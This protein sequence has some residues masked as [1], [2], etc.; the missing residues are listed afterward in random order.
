PSDAN[1]VEQLIQYADFAMYQVKNSTKGEFNEFD[2]ISYKR[3]SFLIKKTEMLNKFLDSALTDY[4]FQPIVSAIDGEVYGYE[5]LMRS[6]IVDMSSPQEILLLARA[7]AKL[8]QIERLTWFE[9]ARTCEYH[10]GKINGRKIFINSIPNQML[11]AVD[12]S[13]FE[14]L[15][16][17][18][19]GQIVTELTENEKFDTE[20]LKVKQACARNWGSEIAIDDFGTGYNSE[21]L[22]LAI[23]PQYIKI[24]MGVVRDIH[25]DKNRQH[26]LQGL[27][28]YAHDHGIKVIAE[29]VEKSEEM[30]ILIE[31]GVDYMQGFYL[32]LVCPTPIEVAPEI[33]EEIKRFNT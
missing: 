10:K 22:L 11:S 20:C 15:H 1:T 27:I 14:T 29:G 30:K 31:F 2:T 4:H 6:R 26:I 16:P 7:Q 25:L 28:K 12:I 32:G 19:L 3:D 17:N 23:T 21:A 5:L 18:M 33:R 9:A 24:D 8:Y 13:R